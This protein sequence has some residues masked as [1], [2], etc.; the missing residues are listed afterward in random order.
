V[1]SVDNLGHR[2]G[3]ELRIPGLFPSTLQGQ[4]ARLA[5]RT[6]SAL[7]APAQVSEVRIRLQLP[8]GAKVR[9]VPEPAQLTLGGARFAI[10]ADTK[11]NR[12]EITRRVRL[13]L[14][15]VTPSD[16]PAFAGFCRTVDLAEAAE[17]AVALP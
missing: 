2:V 17:L 8:K 12:V 6:T 13:P 16:Y 10:E 14:Q 4:F 9:A 7:V 15:R 1:L 5:Q 11:E 3:D